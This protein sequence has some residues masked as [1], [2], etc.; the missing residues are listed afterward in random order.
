MFLLVTW[1]VRSGVMENPGAHLRFFR[2]L[3]VYGSPIGIAIGLLGSLIAMSH[4]P[5]D[6]YDGWGIAAGLS[7]VGNLPACLGYVG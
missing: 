7:V 3:A 5:G 2:A 4:T 1:F 6:R